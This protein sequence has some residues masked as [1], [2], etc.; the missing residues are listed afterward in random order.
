VKLGLAV[1]ASW[2]C[3]TAVA[4]LVE[5]AP[6]ATRVALLLPACE[7][8]GLSQSEV[9][10]ALALDLRDEGLVLA[11]LGEVSPDDVLVRI[12]SGCSTEAELTLQ[13]ALRNDTRTRHIDLS[14]LP[15][16]QRARALSLS[17]AELLSQLDRSPE[18]PAD[19]AEAAAIAQATPAAA[20][21]SEAAPA[22]PPSPAAPG[23]AK[24]ASKAPLQP[25][26]EA[27][28]SNTDD[29]TPQSPRKARAIWQLTLAPEL[30]FFQTSSLWGARALG[31]YGAWSAGLDLLNAQQSAP[32][33]SV[34]TFVVHAS[35]AYGFRLLGEAAGS[36]LEAG[37]R[38]GAG[39]TFMI[40]R[41]NATGHAA[42][43]QD[44]YLDIAFGA[45][46]SFKLSSAFRI[47]LGTELGYASGPIGYADNLEIART[48]GGFASVML[49]GGVQL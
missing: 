4:A 48:A 11:P 31:H 32:T 18:P 37:P 15:P 36:L 7:K 35:C 9:Q 44:V 39:R 49:D 16:A 6:R 3:M 13:V 20:T 10:S 21:S 43:A 34:S 38:L 41:A 2:C 19:A 22:K 5:A 28:T 14:E 1:I 26:A 8:P 17:L 24:P 25:A 45:R 29:R 40:A 23:L 33:G 46:Y 27:T 47:G 42:S 12:D 30:R